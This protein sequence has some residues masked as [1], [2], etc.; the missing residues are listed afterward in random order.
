MENQATTE[1]GQRGTYRFGLNRTV[2]SERRRSDRGANDP[3]EAEPGLIMEGERSGAVLEGLIRPPHG[4]PRVLIWKISA[5]CR[6][7]P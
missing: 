7:A 1:A 5:V 3:N 2:D 4:V 6:P